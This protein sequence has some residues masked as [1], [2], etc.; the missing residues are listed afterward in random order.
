MLQLNFIWENRELTIKALE[1]KYFKGAAEAVDTLLG[2]DKQRRDTQS[3]L[4]ATWA[5]SNT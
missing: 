1:R 5:K 4:D 2:L 3:E